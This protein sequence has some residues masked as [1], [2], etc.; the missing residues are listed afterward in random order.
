MKKLVVLGHGTGGTI[1]ATKMRQRLPESQW[2]IT[3]IDKDWQHHYQPGWLFIPFGIYT[4]EDCVKPKTK[5][6]P[7]GVNLVL[8]E[9]LAID[10]EKKEVKT[11]RETFPYDWLVIATGCRIVPEE[12]EGLIDGWGQG[13]PQFLHPGRGPGPPGEDEVLRE[14]PGGGEHRR[15][16]LQ[17]PGGPPGVRLHVGLVFR[18]QRRQGQ[19]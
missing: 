14:G 13:H 8:D 2:E 7:P 9:I 15:T 5:F 12:V 17:V 6:V 16:A 3:V 11:K 19:N 1:I 4:K 18:H 10:P